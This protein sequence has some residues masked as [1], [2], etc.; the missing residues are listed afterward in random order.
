MVMVMEMKI[1]IALSGGVDSAVAAARLIRQGNDVIGYHMIVLE[2][3]P[4]ANAAADDAKAVADHL[5]IELKIVDLREEFRRILNYFTTS[6]MSG[7]TPNPCVVCNDS[8]KFGLLLERMFSFGEEKIATGHYARLVSLDENVFLARALD[9]AKDQSYFLSRIGK[10]KLHD[11][12]FPLGEMTKEE[13][14]QEASGIDLPVHSKKDSQE[15]CFI[16]DRDYR[17]FLKS[18]GIEG[19]PGPITDESGN[20]L[21]R[22]TGLSGYT[23]GQRKGIGVSGRDRYYVKRLDLKNNRLILAQRKSLMS[24]ALVAKDPNW[25]IDPGEEFDCLCK[26]RSSMKP[27]SAK[28]TIVSG[29]K[30]RVDFQEKVW[31][32][33]PGQLAV[34]YIDDLVVGSA[35]IEENCIL[36]SEGNT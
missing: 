35:F 13:V 36:E 5:G 16:P 28:V 19:N 14:R 26:I 27:V 18:R 29:E 3:N 30:I 7:E 31:A 25:Y 1:G 12:L 15:I 22:H 11:I 8:I 24:E 32:V 21:G 6:Y 33:T 10:H 23:I 34:F 9:R 17:S 4:L 20:L 2:G